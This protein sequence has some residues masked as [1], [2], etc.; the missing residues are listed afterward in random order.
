MAI[1]LSAMVTMDKNKNKNKNKNKKLM[2]VLEPKLKNN[3]IQV[4]T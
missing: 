1:N 3:K 2:T 4:S